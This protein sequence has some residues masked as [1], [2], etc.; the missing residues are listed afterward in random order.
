MDLKQFLKEIRYYKKINGLSKAVKKFFL[1]QTKLSK[2]VNSTGY[3]WIYSKQI[4]KRVKKIKPEIFQIEN[5]N[6]CNAKCIM[7]PHTIMKRKGKIMGFEEFKRIINQVME[8]Y[9]IKRFT[10]TG[11]GEP[12]IDKGVIQKIEY[13]NKNYPSVNLELY[14]NGG[15]LTKELTEKL[16]KTNITKITFS[17]NGTRKNYEKIVGISYE[18]TKQNV[19]YFLKRKKELNSKVMTNVSAMILKENKEDIKEFL[20]FWE[21]LSDSVRVYA[22]SNWAGKLKNLAVINNPPF[23]KKRWPCLALW[24]NITV[25]VDGNI[26]MCCRDYE[27]KVKFGNLLKENI[28]EIRKS[29]KFQELLKKQLGFNFNTPICST[30]DNSFDSSL[31]WWD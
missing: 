10:I 28:K 20:K 26:I 25:D 22:P 11:F 9:P 27:S 1:S 16:L 31:D 24:K 19:L 23:K 7:C 15:L 6:L 8:A 12:T 14:T 17:I 18:K 4:K 21:P 2:V 30:C 5:T 13:V 3:C 29:K